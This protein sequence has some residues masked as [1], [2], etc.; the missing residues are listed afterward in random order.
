MMMQTYSKTDASTALKAVGIKPS[1]QRVAIMQYLMASHA[2]PTVDEIYRALIDEYP[3]M[4]RTTVYNTVW[5]LADSGAVKSI[6]IDRNNARFDYT[7]EPHAHF[8]C[9]SCGKIID[10]M[11]GDLPQPKMPGVI[12]DSVNLFYEGLC[13]ECITKQS[14]N[15]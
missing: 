6:S 11:V 4:S 15:N 10:V 7:P 9:R 1:T 12:V 2:H 3:T 8:R 14:Q 13:E 5:L